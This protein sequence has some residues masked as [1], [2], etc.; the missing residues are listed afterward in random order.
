MSN[1]HDEW[2]G[3]ALTRLV[4]SPQSFSFASAP[5]Q[6]LVNY[7]DIRSHGSGTQGHIIRE[8]SQTHATSMPV[9][10]S[11]GYW[12]ALA[13]KQTHPLTME[14]KEVDGDAQSQDASSASFSWAGDDQHSRS[15]TS[16]S[17]LALPD[18]LPLS[19]DGD[20]KVPHELEQTTSHD[21]LFDDDT[22]PSAA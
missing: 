3:L 4:C 18:S 22:Q 20:M 8:Q 13:A 12:F 7:S 17:S 16:D 15:A 21:S 14:P 5:R 9:P 1:I 19:E 2:S 6:S 10:S 11:N